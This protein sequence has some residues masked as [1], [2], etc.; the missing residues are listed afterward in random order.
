MNSTKNPDIFPLKGR[1]LG[2]RPSEEGQVAQLAQR[3][4][5]HRPLP[6]EGGGDPPRLLGPQVLGHVRFGKGLALGMHNFSHVGNIIVVFSNGHPKGPFDQ[7]PL[8][9]SW[10]PL[11][12]GPRSPSNWCPFSPVSFLVGRKVP[13]LKSTTEKIGYQLI[14]TTL[15]EDLV[16]CQRQSA[17]SLPWVMQWLP[18]A[19]VS[20]QEFY[21]WGWPALH[22]LNSQTLA[23]A[24]FRFLTTLLGKSTSLGLSRLW[25]SQKTE[26][27]ATVVLT[28]GLTAQGKLS[29]S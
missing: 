16:A 4:G 22:V 3:A 13:L 25:G 24:G 8:Q 17:R 12:A 15:L 23:I 2:V 28:S 29:R 1:V 27:C 6:P 7:P 26:P 9:A 11:L 18:F 10:F 14:L 21:N 19:V 20:L 5:A